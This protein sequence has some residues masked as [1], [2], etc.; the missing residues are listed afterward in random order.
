MCSSTPR[1]CAFAAIALSSTGALPAA[2]QPINEDF[3]LLASDGSANHQLGSAIALADGVIAVGARFDNDNGNASGSAY[4]FDILTGEELFKLLPNDGDAVGQFG[5]SIAI[6]DGIVA[7]GAIGDD[8][9]GSFAG[10]AYLFDATTGAQLHK[11]LASDGAE[12]DSFGYS[13]AIDNGIVAVGA[14]QNGDN[15]SN[16]GSAY[17]FDASTGAQITKLLPSDGAADDQFGWSIAIADGVV[18]VGAIGDNANGSNSGSAYLFEA[19]TGVQFDKLLPSDGGLADQFG[20]SIAIA[21]NKVAVGAWVDD[22]NGSNSGSAYLFDASTGAQLA[23]LLPSDG[24][25]SDSFGIS[26]AI[27]D[28]LVAVGAWLDDDSGGGSGSAYLFDAVAGTQIAKLLS[29]DG[30]ADDW[31]GWSVAIHN[32]QVAV[33]AI[34]DDD[35]GGSSGSAYAFHFDSD[36]DGLRDDWETNGIPYTD[37]NGDAQR[38]MLDGADPLHKDLYIEVDAMTGFSFSSGAVTLLENAFAAA[39]LSNPDNPDGT[40]NPDGITLHILRNETNLTHIAVWNTDGC[41]PLDHATWRQQYYGTAAER[42]ADPTA[43]ALIE[44]KAKAYRYCIIGDDADLSGLLGCAQGTPGDN[45]VLFFG[46]SFFNTDTDERQAAVFMHEFGHNLGLRHGGGDHKMGKPNYPSIMNYVM[47]IKFNWNRAFWSLDYTRTGKEEFATLNEASLDEN[48]GVGSLFGFY[49]SYKMPFGINVDDGFGNV[50]RCVEYV[51]LDGSAT[52]FG[53]TLGMMFQDG[54]MTSGVSQDLNYAVA[55]TG[56]P[57]PTGFPGRPSFDP[58]ELTLEPYNDWA[59]VILPLLSTRG[60]GAPFDPP[61]ADELTAEIAEWIDA[62]FPAPPGACVADLNGDDE[63]DFFDLSAF[64]NAFAV[65][66]QI[67]DFVDDDIFD[68]FDVQAFLQAFAAGCP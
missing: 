16:S 65:G 12:W 38:F 57:A 2:G 6:D 27:D 14:N 47:T 22:D 44:A 34:Q 66:D 39:P 68:F 10:A 37:S 56:S 52:D 51:T 4:L 50:T 42:A 43:T 15:G 24:A 53:D 21:G 35:N 26:I 58:S 3:K 31:F 32:G 49:S 29:S 17:L 11:L 7:V 20:Y 1:W 54:A 25:A 13:I 8:A 5:Y 59:N 28:G 48:A 18:A 55:C 46:S 33:G 45:F 30:A 9:N 64:L 63:L 23:K 36:G 40:P 19:A 41:W 62:N 60:A 61:P 67:A